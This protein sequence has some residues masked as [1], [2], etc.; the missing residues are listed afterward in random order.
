MTYTDE[1]IVEIHK[2]IMS[3]L[4]NFY[5]NNRIPNIIFHGQSG[6]GK[7]TL[8]KEFI[9]LI[10]GG[11]DKSTLQSYVMYV[12]CSHGKGIKFIRDELKLFAKSQVEGNTFKTVILLNAD[13]LTV[14]AQSALRRCIELF[15]H[16]TRFFIVVENKYMLLKPILSRFCEIHVP[17]PYIKGKTVNLHQYFICQTFQ[18]GRIYVARNEL[19]KHLLQE[20]PETPVEIIELCEDIYN[21]GYSCLDLANYVENSDISHVEKYELL[22]LIQKVKRE[23]RKEQTLCFFV[24]NRIKDIKRGR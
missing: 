21:R 11:A 1:K 14:D 10:Y 2:H 16:S 23:F 19:L 24:L 20:I 9:H 22:V 13:K 12:N 15:S 3:K 5:R 17:S 4:D 6:S 8:L 18:T 7:H